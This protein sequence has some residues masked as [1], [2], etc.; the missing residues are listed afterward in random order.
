[1]R[2]VLLLLLM[3]FVI[4]SFAQGGATIMVK[5]TDAGKVSLANSSIEFLKPD[6]SLIKILLADSAGTAE[7][8]NAELPAYLLRVS[9]VNYTTSYLSVKPAT[10]PYLIILQPAEKKMQGITISSPKPFIMRMADRTVVNLDAGLTNTGTTVLEALEKLPG[11]SVD[12]D[13]NISLKG[14]A[15][16][17]VMMD[18][19]QTFLTGE[20]LANLLNS[21]SSSQIAQIELID[22][23]PSS[24]DAAG[25]AGVIN[26]KFKKNLQRGFNGT[27]NTNFIQGYYPKNTTTLALNYR[28]GV[29]NMY[30][31]YAVNAAQ[32]FTRAEVLR[33]YLKPDGT[34]AAL[35]EQPTFA[36]YTGTSHNLRTGI[37]FTLSKN[38]SLNLGLYGFLNDGKNTSEA[39]AVW[40]KPSHL[41]DSIVKTFG[42]VTR[43]R[44]DA[45]TTLNFKHNFKSS[46]ELSADMDVRDIR[47][48]RYDSIKTQAEPPGVYLQTLR[49]Q[50]PTDIRIFSAQVNYTKQMGDVKMDAGIK[51]SYTN[52]DNFSAYDTLDG[53]S[54]WVADHGKSN[55]FVY[56]E[57]IQAAYV[58]TQARAA[59]WLLQ[60]GLRYE[61]TAYKGRQFG[62]AVVKDSLLAHKYGDLFPSVAVSFESDSINTFSFTAD[63]RIDRPYY[64][65]LNPFIFV[66]NKYT[67]Q[68]GNPFL[69]PQ[70]TWNFG[71][72]HSY[73]NTLTTGINY[74]V[75]R[76]YFSQIFP[77]DSN[78]IILYT[79]GNIGRMRS[80][81]A[82][83]T[84]Q[85][86]PVKWWSFSL[87]SNITRKKFE[88]VVAN[89]NLVAN[90][91]AF[92]VNMNNQV[93]FK[94]GW[95][96]EI[97][98]VYN[99]PGRE[100]LQETLEPSGQ[101]SAAVAKSFAQNKGS[102]RLSVR[103]I[104]YTNW[105]KGFD[106]FTNANESFK[107]TRDSRVIT[108]AF[109][110]RFGKAYKTAKHSEGA[111]GDEMR[112]T[113]NE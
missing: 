53:N 14:R 15:G 91:T 62:N 96:G 21:L 44:R 18:G 81:G 99:A 94:N 103:D 95:T 90:F 29:V 42:T 47:I 22:S 35:L 40:M 5:V 78:G 76:D 68:Q 41:V 7:L 70:Y 106:Y 33:T 112:R 63:R 38:T 39:K 56:R 83:V 37:D 8:H 59:R 93:R 46:G 9:C 110:W 58:M 4:S 28:S 52:T 20:A 51:S 57:N 85:L 82:S 36:K 3:L 2:L 13:G 11:V 61:L 79:K 32:S 89:K 73:K 98:G 1:M 71:V 12:K 54:N 113:G 16:V 10:E 23:P 109:T 66:I 30:L 101:L 88:G 34:T 50:T 86:A 27:I 100:D 64:Q 105:F 84:L 6:S 25:N 75:V 49:A 72:T 69:R 26:L 48:R 92:L 24:M 97:T 104:L 31:N 17:T 67:Y 80:F 19:R 43:N 108:L 60:G 65:D 107:F 87:Q 74:S 111:S 45:G 102:I 55:H 77:A